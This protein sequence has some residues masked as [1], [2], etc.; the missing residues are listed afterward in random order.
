MTYEE[1]KMKLKRNPGV[2]VICTMWS[3]NVIHYY[4]EDF[5]D[6]KGID[7]APGQ[8]ISGI[9]RGFIR[10]VDYVYPEDL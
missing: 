6:S 2:G 9:N 8:F 10:R 3:G 4:Y 7:R 1:M 5:P